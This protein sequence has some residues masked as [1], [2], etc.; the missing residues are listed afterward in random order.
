MSITCIENLSNEIF[1]EIFDYLNICDVYEAFSNLNNY[2]EEILHCPS[3]LFKIKLYSSS[4]KILQNYSKHVK[5]LNKHQIFS[6]D[7]WTGLYI[8]EFLSTFIID[9]SLNRLQSI[10]LHYIKKKES[11]ITLVYLVFLH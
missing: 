2:F 8:N 6:L 7:I 10:K 9:S 3:L 4:N 1:H 5:H 11:H